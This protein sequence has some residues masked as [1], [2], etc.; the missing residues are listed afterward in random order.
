MACV[1]KHNI[2]SL[3]AMK[4]NQNRKKP[5]KIGFLM[6]PMEKILLDVDTSISIMME[7]QKRGHQVFYVKPDELVYERKTL[8]AE[9]RQVATSRT[10]GFR[11]VSQKRLDLRSLDVIFN[12]KEPPFDLSYLYLTQLLELIERDV[13]IINSPR[14]VRKANEKL[15][16]LEFPKWIPPTFVS[17]EP[18]EIETFF[19]KL[20]SD[21]IVKPLDERGGKGIRLIRRG[22]KNALEILNEAT[23]CGAKWVMA[24]QFLKAGL[25]QGDRR[26]LLLNGEV[27]GQFAKIPKPGEFRANLSLGARY[28]RAELTAKEHRLIQAIRSKLA[29]D[30]L[31]FVGVDVIDG[32]LL[33]INVTSPAGLPEISELEGARPEARVMDFLEEQVSRRRR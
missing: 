25:T 27:I 22:A 10:S 6:D 33:E 18:I 13:F 14:G 4:L 3:S 26:I 23:Q 21:V 29:K 1:L 2:L 24:Q 32:K 17:D 8:F 31:Y 19:K 5:L 12:R 16:I 28:V 20:K 11:I 9:A 30:G 7:A 15:Y